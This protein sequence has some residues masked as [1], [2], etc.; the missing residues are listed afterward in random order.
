MS[1]EKKDSEVF[2]RFKRLLNNQQLET[3]NEIIKE[4]LTI[5]I[6][7][8]CL[9][10]LLGGIYYLRYKDE[11]IKFLLCRFLVI[12]Y[13]V[14]LGFYY[15]SPKKPL[16]LYSLTTREQTTAWTDIYMEMKTRWKKSLIIG[17]IGYVILSFF[18]LNCDKCNGWF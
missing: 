4:R 5:Y 9:G 2:L 6:T 10:L 7:G 13:M 8:M 16:M 1:I 14:K 17:F 11:K 15:F 3:Y 18:L 12:V